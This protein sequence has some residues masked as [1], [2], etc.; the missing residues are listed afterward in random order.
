MQIANGTPFNQQL[1]AQQ[2]LRHLASE[3]PPSHT[4][5]HDKTLQQAA[6]ITEDTVTISQ[7]GKTLS[8]QEQLKAPQNLPTLPNN[9]D[10]LDDYVTYKKAQ[11]EYQIY[12]DMVGVP[13]G[14]GDGLSPASAYYL[15]NNDTARSAVINANAQQQNV[16]AMQTYAAT[17][18]QASQ[19]Y[20]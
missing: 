1:A 11:L 20:E 8:E 4:L 7:M 14:K 13:T 17:S 15:S 6:H 3:I 9:G 19:W 16:T 18:Q 12:S 2:G 5:D 10:R